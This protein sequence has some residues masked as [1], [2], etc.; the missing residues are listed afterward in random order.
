MAENETKWRIGLISCE[1]DPVYGAPLKEYITSWLKPLQ[2]NKDG[3]QLDVDIFD[4]KHGEYPSDSACNKY[5][6]F[7][8]GGSLSSVTDIHKE[9]WISVLADKL[10][11]MHDKKIKMFG[12]C[13]GHQ[14][15]AHALGGEVKMR[16]NGLKINARTMKVADD[17]N[18][19]LFKDKESDI[20][21]C[22][23]YACHEDAVIR[24]PEGSTLLATSHENP[25]E[26]WIKDGC[27]MGMQAHP[28]LGASSQGRES[29]QK[30]AQNAVAMGKLESEAVHEL[31]CSMTTTQTNDDWAAKVLYSFFNA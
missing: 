9:Q 31:E 23:L 20:K 13:F 1:D 17:I 25:N 22:T 10:R 15:L 19:K 14:I 16:E 28:E 6:G 3:P 11:E 27:V 30:L 12:L 29:L 18:R 8:V 5:A 7:I 2:T 4:A 26:L 24:L 21:T